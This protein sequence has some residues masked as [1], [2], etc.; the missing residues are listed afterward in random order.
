MLSQTTDESKCRP[1]PGRRNPA[2]NANLEQELDGVLQMQIMILMK[3]LVALRQRD[4][5]DE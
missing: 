1:H 3:F 2:E 5:A 4:R